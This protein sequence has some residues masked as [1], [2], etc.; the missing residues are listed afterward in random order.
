MESRQQLI[1]KGRVLHRLPVV[2]IVFFATIGC[3]ASIDSE[4]FSSI[5]TW[6]TVACISVDGETQCHWTSDNEV[7]QDDNVEG[8]VVSAKS[9]SIAPEVAMPTVAAWNTAAGIMK[10]FL[11]PNQY[12]LFLKAAENQRDCK[13]F[14]WSVGNKEYT[15]VI[16]R[17]EN[18]SYMYFVQFGKNTT[19]EASSRSD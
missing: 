7:V 5:A 10:S 16:I 6:L 18:V 17:L 4:D 8:C 9:I 1:A 11:E 2:A 12:D 3:R 14:A 15:A 13:R 19:R